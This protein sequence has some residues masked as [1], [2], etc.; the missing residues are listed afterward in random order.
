MTDTN[1]QGGGESAESAGQASRR[2][3]VGGAG[4]SRE[5][6]GKGPEG[7]LAMRSARPVTVVRMA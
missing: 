4:G 7:V 5:V 1:V 2:G 6:G 3:P